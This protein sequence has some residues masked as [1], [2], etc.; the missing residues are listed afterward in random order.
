MPATKN[1][2]V[3]LWHGIDCVFQE[4]F[5]VPNLIEAALKLEAGEYRYQLNP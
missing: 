4:R 3:C 5:F 1:G 2:E